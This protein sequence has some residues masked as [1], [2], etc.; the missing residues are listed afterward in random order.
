MDRPKLDITQARLCES[1]SEHLFVGEAYVFLEPRAYESSALSWAGR[2]LGRR[3]ETPILSSL[4]GGTVCFPGIRI[5]PP[6]LPILD[7]CQ[8]L[9]VKAV[10][11]AG[12][13]NAELLL[14]EPSG[15]RREKALEI[16][17]PEHDT[18][19][20]T[21][22]LDEAG[23]A[24]VEVAGLKPGAYE[25]AVL[26]EEGALAWCAFSIL[27]P[28]V[29]V[30]GVRILEVPGNH[31]ETET[32][33][34]LF[35]VELCG[36]PLDGPLEAL[37]EFEDGRREKL[38]GQVVGGTL[39]LIA[40][41]KGKISRLA[42]RGC[43]PI[44]PTVVLD[45]LNWNSPGADRFHLSSLGNEIWCS[46][47]PVLPNRRVRGL[48]LSRGKV[49][50]TNIW[51]ERVDTDSARLHVLSPCEPAEILILDPRKQRGEERPDVDPIQ[52]AIEAGGLA[53][54][55][56]AQTGGRW[57]QHRFEKLEKG[58]ILSL[59]VPAP[60]SLLF[61]GAVTDGEPWEACA[62][63]LKPSPCQPEI[64]FP[65]ASG[66]KSGMAVEVLSNSDG[67]CEVILQAWPGSF[68]PEDSLERSLARTMLRFLE[69]VRGLP[70]LS[71]A[72]PSLAEV[73][74]K[75]D[76]GDEGSAP[77][78]AGP[79]GISPSKAAGL[80]PPSGR[81][82]ITGAYFLKASKT[83]H[84]VAHFEIPLDPDIELYT[85]EAL[86]LKNGDWA[87]CSAHAGS[88]EDPELRL[89]L[90]RF[91]G[92]NEAV[93]AWV[94]LRWRGPRPHCR[95]F[96]DGAEIF[97]EQ[98]GHAAEPGEKKEDE[99]PRTQRAGYPFLAVAG[100]Y[101]VLAEAPD[102]RVLARAEGSTSLPETAFPSAIG[103]R[104][105]PAVGDSPPGNGENL[106][107]SVS[108]S[109]GEKVPGS[110]E[111]G[112]TAWLEQGGRRRKSVSVGE[113]FHLVVSGKSGKKLPA[114]MELLL[115]QATRS[116]KLGKGQ[117]PFAL[118]RAD[119]ELRVPLLAL[120]ATLDR[121][122]QPA[123]GQF[124]IWA[125]FPLEVPLRI[126]ENR[127]WGAK[128]ARRLKNCSRRLFGKGELSDLGES[129]R[130]GR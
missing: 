100:R 87:S 59:E 84:G 83:S 7:L 48:Y 120:E 20:L 102:G 118:E 86:V 2:M 101:E 21:V 15:S 127:R 81:S 9:P 80:L 98:P 36:E 46:A 82:A 124:L 92:S 30:F 43:S 5:Q 129:R 88:S 103:A 71:T 8:I 123:V 6:R 104:G 19:N 61:I 69:K 121:E 110:S 130:T 62:T 126:L 116:P 109:V 47:A 23:M 63:L 4:V 24:M 111:E 53:H 99:K 74:R 107:R 66:I 91:L 115:P 85:L 125:G 35:W 27:G 22:K 41:G 40:P 112:L 60:L 42:I 3:R 37:L 38:T 106:H 51:L 1:Y 79:P 70:R 18:K 28:H 78:T 122:G 12:L 52:G 13:E 26:G 32:G 94:V 14:V 57:R 33:N 72:V 58:E 76:P 25:A 44:T 45:L 105:T 29:P 77:S 17:S 89:R 128:L 34:L 114:A 68:A 97:L 55:K 119:G 108:L 50:P 56:P 64:R 90:P 54:G 49:R 31:K 93:K 11:R 16:H 75:G 96:R 39:E 65:A 117:G 10:F 67:E 73:M 113:T 95:L